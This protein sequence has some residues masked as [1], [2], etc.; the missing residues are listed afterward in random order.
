MTE[1]YRKV[2]PMPR[3]R[4]RV[5]YQVLRSVEDCLRIRLQKWRAVTVAKYKVEF[6]GD[7]L[8]GGKRLVPVDSR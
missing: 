7:Y 6:P 5:D 8:R 1:A 4:L 2:Y 3:T